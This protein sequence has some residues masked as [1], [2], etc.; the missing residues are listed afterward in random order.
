LFDRFGKRLIDQFA[1]RPDVIR[2]PHRWRNPQGFVNS[3]QVEMRDTDSPRRHG[4]PASSK[5][6]WSVE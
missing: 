1:D 6:R 3:A 2:Y 4:S 5:S